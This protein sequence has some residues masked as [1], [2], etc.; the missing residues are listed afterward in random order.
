MH[1]VSDPQTRPQ[2]PPQKSSFSVIKE[3]RLICKHYFFSFFN[4]W[5]YESP[6]MQTLFTNFKDC[7]VNS[8]A[9][10]RKKERVFA[11]IKKW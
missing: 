5:I 8:P 7:T 10:R 2:K 9:Q 6:F 11:S 1:G 4:E 3:G